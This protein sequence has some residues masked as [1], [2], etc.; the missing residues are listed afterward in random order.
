LRVFLPAVYDAIRTSPEQFCGYKAIGDQADKE[1]AKAF[2][3]VWLQKVPEDL[4]ASVQELIQ[5]LFPRLKSVWSNMH[6][7]GDSLQRWRAKLQVC[8]PDIFPAYFRLS[9]P[10]GTVTRA[11]VDAL[12]EPAL[13]TGYRRHG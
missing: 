13:W 4:R 9:L 11:D 6:Y 12:P 2:H 7:S 5:R 10:A 1:R 8:V 3:D